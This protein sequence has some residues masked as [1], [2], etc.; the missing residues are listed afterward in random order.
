[1]DIKK[2]TDYSIDA[3]IEIS[4]YKH[5]HTLRKFATYNEYDVCIDGIGKFNIGDF[6]LAGDDNILFPENIRTELSE[7]NFEEYSMKL[8]NV[9]RVV[10]DMLIKN[11]SSDT[12]YTY[13]LTPLSCDMLCDNEEIKITL[14]EIITVVNFHKRFDTDTFPSLLTA[15]NQIGDMITIDQSDLVNNWFVMRIEC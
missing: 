6:K 2:I 11:M 5:L 4:D 13:L 14:G 7:K 3:E 9:K 15:M 12:K 8:V 10:N 1:M